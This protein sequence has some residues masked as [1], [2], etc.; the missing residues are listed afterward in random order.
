[1][2]FSFG[3]IIGLACLVMLAACQSVHT[4][5]HEPI[6]DGPMV[7]PIRK[8][9]QVSPGQPTIV[10]PTVAD[11]EAV[12]ETPEP[13]TTPAPARSPAKPRASYNNIQTTERV[14]AMTFDDGPHPELTPKLLDML[15]ARNIK[16]TFYVV[17]RNV[18]AYPEIMKR[19]VAE[20]HEV[21][22]HTYTHP[23]LTKIGRDGVKSQIDRST[24][25][26]RKTAGVTPT[27]MRPPYG[28]TNATLNRRMNDE[29]G[30]K[31]IMW[32]V[33]P[34][35][36]RYRNADRVANHIIQNAKP[37]DIILAH[38]IHPSTIAAM[39]RTLDTLTQKGFRFL[40]VSELIELE[41]APAATPPTASL[42]TP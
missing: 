32:S 28:A 3:P 25:A 29:F 31:V 6:A 20:G 26:I 33:D 22:N 16:A 27:N 30:L 15:K 41:Q 13:T 18:D 14:V 12:V 38:D 23:S 4:Q 8:S 39:P 35:D 9:S 24:A 40:T 1:M 42:D 7:V 11:R 19:I 10:T 36:W 21:G 34:Q 37:G 2:K 5:P 17:G